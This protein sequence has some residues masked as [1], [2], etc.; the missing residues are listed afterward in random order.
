MIGTARA[1]FTAPWDPVLTR[2]GDALGLRALTDVLADVVA[3]E[4]NYRINDARW[5]TILA[6]CL[7]HAN[8]VYHKSVAPEA[9]EPLDSRAG[10]RARYQWLRPLELLWVRRTI[11]IAPN[12]GRL[13]SLPGQRTM[14]A[15]P[16]E[17][18]AEKCGLSGA[19]LEGYRQTG[20]YG[21][22]RLAFRRWPQLTRHGDG[23]TPDAACRRLADWLAQQM[24]AAPVL[25]G[26]ADG[27][28]R[29]SA[30]RGKQDPYRFWEIR[31]PTYQQCAEDG[32]EDT[33]HLTLPRPY[34]E[35]EQLP[36]AHLL[37]G[38]IFGDDRGGRQRRAVV[39]QLESSQAA[40]HLELCRTLTESAAPSSPLSVLHNFSR[41]A[42]AGM[43]VVHCVASALHEANTLSISDATKVA[44]VV[45]ACDELAEAARVWRTTPHVSIRHIET[46]HLFASV[47]RSPDPVAC[48]KAVVQHHE[49]HGGGIRSFGLRG[50]RLEARAMQSSASSGYQFRLAPLYRLAVQCGVVR[51]I[52]PAL[53]GGLTTDAGALSDGED[54]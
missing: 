30:L 18:L 25:V 53:L 3:P 22:Y 31:C 2:R 46:A 38:I 21:A 42:D 32:L 35:M 43:D 9:D 45:E 7:V 8:D 5:L 39:R 29:R 28:T 24:I 54:A 50:D 1:L 14:R 13:R 51:D 12:E 4:T 26:G 6:W 15:A 27:I 11:A 47:A 48:L 19:Q 34:A 37:R 41:L 33:D 52:P 17:T 20:A 10:Q 44:G 36:E 49:L 16:Q 40:T 23:F